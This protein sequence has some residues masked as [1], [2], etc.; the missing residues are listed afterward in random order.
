VIFLLC[1]RWYLRYSLTYRNLEEMIAERNPP[2]DH[3]T[4]CR[5]VISRET[6]FSMNA[7]ANGL[8]QQ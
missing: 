2:V 3:V 7:D 1:I 8:R 6:S 4:I 5:R